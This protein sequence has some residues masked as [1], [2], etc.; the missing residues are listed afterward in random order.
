MGSTTGLQWARYLEQKFNKR[1]E[2]KKRTKEFAETQIEWALPNEFQVTKVRNSW[3]VNGYKVIGSSFTN[4]FVYIL[5]ESDSGAVR[6][7]GLTSDP[8]R[9]YQEHRQNNKLG[10]SFKLVIVDVGDAES[11]KRWAL[12]YCQEGCDLLNV[13]LTKSDKP[14]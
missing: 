2:A 4:S 5:K 9:R 6:Y 1:E 11:E 14:T 13:T 3:Y 12:R 10:V 8:V 7:V